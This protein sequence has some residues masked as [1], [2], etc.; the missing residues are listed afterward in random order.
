MVNSV[1][2]TAVG[3]LLAYLLAAHAEAFSH[4]IL[5]S[6]RADA[7]AQRLKAAEDRRRGEPMDL[8]T[9]Q[10]VP[11][12]LTCVEGDSCTAGMNVTRWGI[13]IA[14]QNSPSQPYLLEWEAQGPRRVLLLAKQDPLILPDVYEAVQHL[15]S[16]G[17]EVLVEGSLLPLLVQKF[18]QKVVDLGELGLFDTAN[19]RCG[20][21]LII[22]FGGD[23]LLMHCNS[24][25]DDAMPVPPIIS[26]DF[27]SLGFLAP[28]LYSEFKEQIDSMFTKPTRITLRM[29]LECMIVRHKDSK[30]AVEAGGKT[31][32]HVLNEVVIDRGMAPFLSLVDI[33]CNSQY[34]T[35]IQGDGVIIA[36]PTGSTA[37]SLAAGGSMVHPSVPAILITPVCAHTLSIRPLILPDVIT[38]E[39]SVPLDGRAT[40]WVSFDG[41]FRQELD[42]GDSIIIRTSQAPMPTVTKEN[43]T[44]D[45]FG[46]LRETLNFN[47][48]VRQGVKPE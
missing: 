2:Q 1:T 14:P 28:F 31:T 32:H 4:S 21:D 18:G 12:T 13:K 11:F 38:L 42:R 39:C 26:F 35:T 16:K 27:G 37:Y 44:G 22:T 7:R 19:G 25:F 48:R 24:L 8:L 34:L 45:W 3:F 23:G 20:V 40:G 33:K 36:T 41:K 46:S 9:V 15:W 29:R 17:L 43:F 30:G 6:S 47:N 5:H 10:P